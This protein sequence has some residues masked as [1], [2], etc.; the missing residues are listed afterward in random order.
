MNFVGAVNRV[1]RIAGIIRGDTDPIVSFS[2]LQHGATLNLALIAIQDTFTDLMAFYN[3]PVERK[4]GSIT[5]LNGVRTY[6]LATDFVQFWQSDAFF[7][8]SVDENQIREYG[9]GERQ[10]AQDI[11]NYKTDIGSPTLWYYV[12]ASTKMIGVYQTPNITY[13]QRVWTYEY[14]YD[15]VPVNATDTMPFIRDI[16]TFAF[17]RCAAVRFQSM[18]N[19]NPK[20]PNA[21]VEQHPE[22]INAR[23]TLL[24]LI[25]PDKPNPYYGRT[26]LPS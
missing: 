23:S 7:F 16:E 18:F 8:D 25:T 15:V 6:A 11:I 3:F 5:L 26:Y 20:S 13:D 10:L 17:C 24:A 4:S 1:L 9:G 21:P 12:E 14:E 2:D 22:Y 19:A